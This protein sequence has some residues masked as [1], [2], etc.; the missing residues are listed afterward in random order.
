AQRRITYSSDP[1][2]KLGLRDAGPVA[3]R[4]TSMPFTPPPKPAVRSDSAKEAPRQKGDADVGRGGTQVTPIA[5][6]LEKL[7]K[8]R[9]QVVTTTSLPARVAPAACSPTACRPT[10]PSRSCCS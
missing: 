9:L 3:D 1:C 8:G 6:L 4:T 10:R 2:D 7:S 5:P